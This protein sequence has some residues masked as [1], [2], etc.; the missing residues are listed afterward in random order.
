MFYGLFNGG[1]TFNPETDI[2]D[3]SEKVIFVT[4]GT[5]GIGLQT[6]LEL[7][8]HNPSHIYISGRNKT[9]AESALKIIQSAAPSTKVTFLTCD[10]ADLHDVTGCVREFL[11][12][13]KR[14]DILILNAGIM[15]SQAATTKQGYEIQFGT[16]HVGHFLLTKLLLPTLEETAKLPDTRVRV[17]SVASVAHLVAPGQGIVFSE[18]RTD[19]CNWYTFQRY[20]QSKL[21]NILF[22]RHLAELV[23]EKG[24]KLIA[25]SIHP[26]VVDTGLYKSVEKWYLIPVILKIVRRMKLYLVDSNTGAKT[27]LWA[28][29][30][31]SSTVKDATSESAKGK[32]VNGE[33]YTPVAQAGEGGK[34]SHDKELA[35]KLW[36][37]TEEEVKDYI[38]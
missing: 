6:A 34:S 30:A 15:G 36:E 18:L 7:A 3:L 13:E 26:G 35:R 21:A 12:R 22:A 33:Y 8:R 4:G 14:L 1:I 19:M 5:S 10:L 25:V 31:E 9:S 28:A 29:T 27:Q 20:G 37:W 38:L 2:K 16:N 17:V 11:R 23:D 32:V 24:S